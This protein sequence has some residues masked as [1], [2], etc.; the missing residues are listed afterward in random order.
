MTNQRFRNTFLDGSAHFVTASVASFLP[1]LSDDEARRTILRSWLYGQS[2]FDVEILGFVVMPEHVHVLVQGS[3]QGARKFL[4]YSLQRSARHL[5][6]MYEARS[7]KG[8][9]RASELLAN[10][11]ATGKM[12]KERARCVAVSEQRDVR[13]WPHSC[14]WLRELMPVGRESLQR[15]AIPA[16]YVPAAYRGKKKARRTPHVQ[17]VPPVDDNWRHSFRR[18]ENMRKTC[19][20]PSALCGVQ[21]LVLARRRR[22]SRPASEPPTSNIEAGS[23]TGAGP[24]GS[25]G[26]RKY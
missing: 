7:R 14:R 10:L 2:R 24:P 19:G 1:I 9:G 16:A 21:L 18:T 3:A 20:G 5:R 12:W 26:T 11:Q 13:R 17:E 6:E 15:L 23:G 25:P 8:D 22:M 4:Q